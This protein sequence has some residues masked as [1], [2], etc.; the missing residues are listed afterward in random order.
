MAL[1]RALAVDPQVLLLDEP[2]G[3]LDAKVRRPAQLAAP[4]ARRGPRD[5]RSRDPRPGGGPRRRRPHRGAQPGPDRA[6][7]RSRDAVRP[8]DQRLRDVLPRLGR[9][10]R[11]PA[12]PAARHRPREDHALAVAE[13]AKIPGSPG[14]I[15]AVVE[16]VVRL[17]FEVRVDLRPT[18]A[19]VSRPRSPDA[20]PTPALRLG[21]GCSRCAPAAAHRSSVARARPGPRHRRRHGPGASDGR[22]RTGRL[23]SPGH[24]D[25]RRGG[26]QRVRSGQH[27]PSG[28]PG[29]TCPA[30]SSRR[31]SRTCAGP[32]SC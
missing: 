22:L 2:F 25:P 6:G 13:D 4:A 15:E 10:A 8:A 21:R 17:G 31:S 7:R 11:R 32:G 1:A 24:A 23:R 29:R 27:R 5:H 3:A 19:S 18:L 12:G 20:T 30:S 14:V 28:A 16:R 26:G 9:P